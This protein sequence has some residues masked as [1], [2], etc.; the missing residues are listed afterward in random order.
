MKIAIN[1]HILSIT[2]IFLFMTRFGFLIPDIPLISF[3]TT[4]DV[5]FVLGL[6]WGV[7]I[8]ICYGKNV[9]YGK[10][11]RLI[12]FGFVLTLIS[13]AAAVSS[14]GQS[15]SLGIRPQRYF[16]IC[17]FLYFPISTLLYR[18]LIEWN[19]IKRIVKN[20]AKFQLLLF[21]IQFAV[22]NQ[23]HFLDI[24]INTRNGMPR[25]YGDCTMVNFA[26]L[27]VLN[28]FLADR[29]KKTNKANIIFLG[30]IILFYAFVRQGRAITFAALACLYFGIIFSKQRGA[31]KLALMVAAGVAVVFLVQTPLMQSFI[32]A[33]LNS[34][35]D[36]NANVRVMSQLFYL[37]S[38]ADGHWLAGLG[39]VNTNCAAAVNASGILKGFFFADN[40]IYGFM[41]QFGL[42]GLTW[43][44]LLFFSA[45]SFS[46]KA[47]KHRDYL[48]MLFFLRWLI[49]YSTNVEFYLSYFV[50]P[51]VLVLIYMDRQ[52][53]QG[54]A[55]VDYKQELSV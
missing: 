27:L 37:D 52:S 16:I 4:E 19:D 46:I 28:D 13:S 53:Y 42:I 23:V 14:F 35:S 5:S 50:M 48:V 44:I 9:H 36:I 8:L 34:S 39:Y 40:G 33:V 41:Y 7:Y 24:M 10:S 3:L 43:V 22:A 29:D 21:F 51:L 1:K 18:G 55:I 32:D 45:V 11:V 54:E 2:V 12:L 47:F 17:L 26:Y 15:F 6:L 30:V 38:L 49:T 31:R 20:V 25:L